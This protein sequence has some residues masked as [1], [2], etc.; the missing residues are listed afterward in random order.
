MFFFSLFGYLVLK[1]TNFLENGYWFRT[2]TNT[3]KLQIKEDNAS[4]WK[5]S[6]WVEETIS[7]SKLKAKTHNWTFRSKWVSLRRNICLNK[8]MVSISYTK[9]SAEII[10]SLVKQRF[11][12]FNKKKINKWGKWSN[13]VIYFANFEDV[14][15]DKL[16]V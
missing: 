13:L 12:F 14:T 8:K 11:F 9:F 4:T 15:N 16:L 5:V 3:M 1:T 6:E 2:A 7:T 10:R